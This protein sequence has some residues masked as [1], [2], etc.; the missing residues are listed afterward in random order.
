MVM[1][2][3]SGAHLASW[4]ASAVLKEPLRSDPEIVITF[5]LAIFQ[6][7]EFPDRCPERAKCYHAVPALASLALANS[8][9]RRAERTIEAVLRACYCGKNRGDCREIA[10]GT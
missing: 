7:L 2:I 6:I 3:P 1:P 9:C 10:G 5:N 4:L 8:P